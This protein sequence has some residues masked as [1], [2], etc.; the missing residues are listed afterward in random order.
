MAK[1]KE[2]KQ[3]EL[4]ALT[5]KLG[6]SNGAVFANFM[7]LSVPEIQDLRKR[8]KADD[9]EMV[10]AKKNLIAL[11]L[12]KAGLEKEKATEMEGG[13][14]VVFGYQDE[15]APAR[16]VAE[17]AKDHEAISFHGGILEGNFID[18]E[19]VTALSKLP[20]KQELLGRLVGSMKS[21]VTGFANVL[22]GNLRGLVQALNQIKEQKA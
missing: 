4:A 7:G 21:P 6:Q 2:Q 5:E 18:V 9:S 22:N 12:E 13:V 15:V 20:S 11:M 8:L 10:V 14:S 16:V 17:F 3:E 19:K 1:T